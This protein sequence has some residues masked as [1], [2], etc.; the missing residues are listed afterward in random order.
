METLTFPVSPNRRS[1]G[2]PVLG[3]T[4][5]RCAADGK[6]GDVSLHAPQRPGRI[7]ARRAK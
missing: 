6:S 3:T 7:A 2:T 1:L 4:I 5:N